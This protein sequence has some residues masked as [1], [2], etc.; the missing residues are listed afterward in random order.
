MI[1]AP[2]TRKILYSQAQTPAETTPQS[3]A[4]AGSASPMSIRA[5]ILPTTFRCQPRCNEAASA[6]QVYCQS[7]EEAERLAEDL[8]DTEHRGLRPGCATLIEDMR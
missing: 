3:P 8:K 1:R 4:R 7:I 5:S 2:L 6:E